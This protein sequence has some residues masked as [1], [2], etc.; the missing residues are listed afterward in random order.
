[1]SLRDIFLT[2]TILDNPPPGKADLFRFDKQ[3]YDV[4]IIGDVSAERLRTA[5]PNAD[6]KIEELVRD[7]RVGLLMTGGADSLGRDWRG[8]KIAQAL[9]VELD[10][11]QSDERVAFVPTREGLSD[12]VLR[13]S[14]DPKESEE[15]WAKLSDPINKCLLDGFTRLGRPKV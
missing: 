1:M 4:I 8:T 9:P 7:K 13:L 14:P 11:T 12:F 6:T 3:A 10:G 15:L 5:S 2:T